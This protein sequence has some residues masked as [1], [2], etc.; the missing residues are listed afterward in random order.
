MPDFHRISKR[1]QKGAAN[2]EDVV[3]VYQALLLLPG[4][5]TTLEN[6]GQ[7]NEKWVELIKEAYVDDL[8]VSFAKSELSFRVQR[9]ILACS[10]YLQ[11]FSGSLYPLQEMVET[12]IDFSELDRHNYVIK[13]EFDTA[14]QEIKDELEKV[15]EN[16]DG[17]HRDVA[18]DLDM[19]MD[20]KVLHFE[21][22]PMYGHCFRLTKK[23]R[24]LYN[25][26]KYL[27]EN[28]PDICYQI[29]RKLSLFATIKDTSSCR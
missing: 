10:I 13:P 28:D 20:Q 14:L 7:D 25:L 21:Q 9:L 19:D 2:L 27:A 16:L 3:R 1:F 5:L 12:T 15:T 29:Y 22:H 4:L 11:S 6:G 8:T 24:P 18:R 23:V 17:Q 26:V